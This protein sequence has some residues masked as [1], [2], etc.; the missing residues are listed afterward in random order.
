[1]QKQYIWNRMFLALWTLPRISALST[2]QRILHERLCRWI[3][4]GNLFRKWV[5]ILQVS[6]FFTDSILLHVMIYISYCVLTRCDFGYYGLECRD[7]CSSFCK[8]SRDCDHVT[9]FCKNG[10]KSGWRGNDC[11][12]GNCAFSSFNSHFRRVLIIYLVL[13]YIIEFNV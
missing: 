11:L 10:C 7:Q 1:M 6:R 5:F 3:Q 2:Y 8:T 9:G 13:I 4:R 12:E